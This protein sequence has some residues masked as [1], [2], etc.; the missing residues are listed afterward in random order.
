MSN[1]EKSTINYF[2]PSCQV[3]GCNGILNFHLN[4]DRL[5]IRYQCGKNSEHHGDN[6]YFK[7][8]E[9]CFLKEKK[10]KVYK[11]SKCFSIIYKDKIYKCKE[12]KN[13]YCENC[14]NLDE[15]LKKSFDNLIIMEEKIKMAFN[16]KCPKCEHNICFCFKCLQNICIYCSDVHKDHQMARLA[17]LSQTQ[18]SVKYLLDKIEEKSKINEK[19]IYSIDKWEKEIIKK[20]ET[21]KI[22]LRDQISLLKKLTFNFNPLFNEPIYFLN[23]WE[24]FYK[25]NNINMNNIKKFDGTYGLEEQSKYIMNL[26]FQKELKNENKIGFVNRSEKPSPKAILHK[27]D[28]RNFIVYEEYDYKKE[29]HYNFGLKNNGKEFLFNFEEKV[30]SISSSKDKKEIYVCLSEWKR[31]VIF[32]CNLELFIIEKSDNELAEEDLKFKEHFNKCIQISGQY[33]ATSDNKKVSIWSMIE[34]NGQ[35]RKK[36]IN[37]LNIN[38]NTNVL[39]LLSVNNEYFISCQPI[40]KNISFVNVYS[41]EKDKI[42]YDKKFE[43]K[44]DSKNILTLLNKYICVNC[45][46]GIVLIYIKTKEI[47]QFIENKINSKFI[48]LNR[49]DSF[50]IV[51]LFNCDY[52]DYIFFEHIDSHGYQ[53]SLFLWGSIEKYNMIDGNFERVE[54]YGQIYSKE[55]LKNLNSSNVICFN[56]MFILGIEDFFLLE[57]IS[58]IDVQ[59]S[60]FSN[61]F[62]K[63]LIKKNK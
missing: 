23:F 59:L 53:G 34:N 35:N 12:C 50:Y 4:E 31:V 43:F 52:K 9:N 44:N 27:L 21:L 16:K 33:L 2:Y 51:N 10:E 26:F 61:N 19:L 17:A 8:F 54:K 18:E 46:T 47:V 39:D 56:N 28:D 49:Q 3:K 58:F 29:E 57:E 25:L 11:C 5:C 42:L 37:I 24:L 38:F 20:A 22:K 30:Y 1:E 15:H 41:L 14:K 63:V 45:L 48:C 60:P 7:T 6:I 55:N 36:Y 32:N 13:I 62:Y 40:N